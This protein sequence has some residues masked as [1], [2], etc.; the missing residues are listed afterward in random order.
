MDEDGV[1]V[2]VAVIEIEAVE[3]GVFVG[4]QGAVS[5]DVGDQVA[6][7]EDVGDLVKELV[8]D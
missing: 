7:I 8:G 4:V 6:L 1:L 2:D 3:L 5:E